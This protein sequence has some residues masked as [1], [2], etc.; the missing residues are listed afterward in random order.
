MKDESKL[1]DS[2]QLKNICKQSEDILTKNINI[3]DIK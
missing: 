3:A 1:L 2:E